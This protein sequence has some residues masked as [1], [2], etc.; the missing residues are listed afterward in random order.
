M[1]HKQYTGSEGGLCSAPRTR[2]NSNVLPRPDAIATWLHEDSTVHRWKLSCALHA[3][4][5]RRGSASGAAKMDFLGYSDMPLVHP[6]SILEHSS[7]V[8]AAMFKPFLL[9][10]LL[11]VSGVSCDFTLTILHHNDFHSRFERTNNM[12]QDCIQADLA[13]K[14]C[15]GGATQLHSVMKKYYDQAKPNALKLNAGDSFQ[16]SVWYSALKWEPVAAV[17]DLIGYDAM[18]LGNHEFDDGPGGLLP[19]LKAAKFPV[20]VTNIEDTANELQGLIKKDALIKDFGNEKVGK[21]AWKN[22]FL[23]LCQLFHAQMHFFRYRWCYHYWH[24][25]NGQSRSEYFVS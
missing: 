2:I 23:A 16:G 7:S 1:Q 19:F 11:T 6:R 14:A 20:L 4:Q 22:F 8:M 17:M 15:Y 13:A 10:L 9:A 12:G 24:K 21:R 25:D 18:T 5:C 3:E